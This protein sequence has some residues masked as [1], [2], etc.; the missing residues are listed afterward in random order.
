M[1]NEAII[2]EC[3]QI[4]NESLSG[5]NDSQNALVVIDYIVRN[6]S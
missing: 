5:N 1:V 6:I 3:K 4:I 2:D